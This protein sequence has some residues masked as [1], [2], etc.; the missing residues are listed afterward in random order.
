MQN[1]NICRVCGFDLGY[2]IWGEDNNSPT[3]DICPCCGVEFGYGDC[4][5]KAIMNFRAN[6]L[7]K[8]GEF[9]DKKFMPKDWDLTKQLNQIPPE[10][11]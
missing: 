7:S 11:K 2:P 6:W 10:W 1:K 4:L 3:Y 9:E 8:G 5:K